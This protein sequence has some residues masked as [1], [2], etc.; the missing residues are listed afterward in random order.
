MTTIAITHID[1]ACILLEINGFRILTDPTLD[2]AGRLYYHGYGAVSRK[3][4]NPALPV[5]GLQ[6]IDLILLNHH[7][8]KDNLV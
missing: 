7:Q 2:N 1:T 6:D 3:T 5:S 8:H 4:D